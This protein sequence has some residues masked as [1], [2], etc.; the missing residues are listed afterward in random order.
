MNTG[1]PSSSRS[2]R[3]LPA[4]FNTALPLWICI[5]PAPAEGLFA[6]VDH[7][8][9]RNSLAAFYKQQEQQDISHFRLIP[10]ECVV[11]SASFPTFLPV[12]VYHKLTWKWVYL[13]FLMKWCFH[14]R[15]QSAI[16]SWT[17]NGFKPVKT[18]PAEFERW[19]RTDEPTGAIFRY[20]FDSCTRCKNG[21]LNAV[22]VFCV[23][24]TSS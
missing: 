10:S 6:V 19:G 24:C 1:L 23:Q 15:Q 13:L 18:S 9:S 14:V 22:I 21:V 12:G 4:V 8:E 11:A 17:S 2:S 5:W 3:V 16:I 20:S 7:Y